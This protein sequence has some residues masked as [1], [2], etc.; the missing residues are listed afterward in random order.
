MSDQHDTP[1]SVHRRTVLGGLAGLGALGVATGLSGSTATASPDALEASG[2]DTFHPGHPR[3][4]HVGEKLWNS[5]FVGPELIGGRDNL[6]P[7][8]PAAEADTENYAPEDFEWSISSKPDDSEAEL[9]YQSSLDP[10]QPR[11]DEGRDN[12]TEFEADVPGTY[13]LEL[14]G[15]DG[16]H[17]LTI[18]AF[19]EPDSAAGGPPRIE[20]EGEYDD[21]TFTIG[22]N[23]ALAP[24]SQA[25][26]DA[27]EVVFLADDRDALSTDDIETDADALTGQVDVDALEGEAARVH[28]VVT[29]GNHQSV[30][31][32]I[33]LEPDGEISL[34]NRA[35][36]WM[37]DGVMYQIFPRSWSGERGETT[38]E[39]LIDGVD[40]LDEL[41]VDAVW[42]TP[43]VPAESVDK[44][45][46]NNNLSGFQ[47]DELPGGGPH[48][49]DTND[50][51]GVAEDLAFDGMD[52]VE[53][54]TAFV[55]ACHERDIKVV[56]DL[57]INHAGRGHP[58]FQDTIAEQ[59]TEPPAPDWEYPPVEAWNEDSKYFDWW[60]R[61]EA[62]VTHDGEVVDPAPQTTGFWGLRVMPNWNFDNVA[63]REH[64]LAVAEFW[65]GEVGVDG[66]R[67]DIA[68]GAPHS[69][70]KD[71]REVVRDNDSEFL[72]LD[73]AIPKDRTFSE[74][75]FDMHFDTDGF[76][77][78]THDV[79]NGLASPSNL[80]DDVRARQEDGFPEYSLL[81]NA[82]ENHDEHRLLNQTVADI[83][84]PNHDEL[85][86]EDWEAGATLQ[87]ACWAAGVTLPGVP[88]VYYGQERQISRYGEGRH[89]GEDDPRGIAAD[90][91]VDIGADVRPGGRQR[92]FMNWDEY[93]E[94][95]FE[96][97]KDLID[98]YHEID[99]LKNDAALV[100]EWYDSDD[101][102]L[103]FGR[104]GSHLS[105]V[106][107]PERAVVIVN[108]ET[109]GLATVELRSEV[110]STDV[111]SG[112]DIAVSSDDERT[113]VDVDEVAILE[114]PTFYAPGD[115]I[116]NLTVAPGT[117][118][119]NGRYRYPTGEQFTDG[120]FDM[121]GVSVHDG[122]DTH[123][124]RVEVRGDLVNHEGYEG[125]FTDQHIQLYLSDG[126]GDGTEL[127]RGG[128]NATFAEPYQY[129]VIADG[130]HGVRVETADGAHV[131]TG[132]VSANPADDSILL[133]FPKGALSGG[134][135]AMNLSILMLG[136]DPE[137]P[138]NVRQVTEDATETT[139]GGAQND[140]A[141]NV[142]DLTTPGDVP[143]FQALAY[144][145][146]TLATI[147]Y[148]P[149]ATDLEEIATFDEPTGE[150]YGPGTYEYP[151]SD[152]FYEGAWDIDELTVSASRDNVEFSFTMATE[153]QNPWG[154]P[155]PFS[156][157]F[158]QIY[159]YD[160]ATDGPE[161]VSGRAGLNANMAS[162]YNYRIVVNGES[163][164]TVESADGETVTSNVET[165]VEGRT[166]SIRVPAD[167]IGWDGDANGGIGIA[168]LVAPFDGFGEGNVRGIGTEAEEY[169]IG[170][171]TGTNDPAVMD[172]ITP[173]GVDR[174]DV[175]SEYGED[176]LVEIP[177]V[178][179]GEVDLPDAGD[180]DV[181]D[182][183]E[184]DADEED[185]DEEAD[186]DEETDPDD[187]AD[188]AG[189][190]TV[191]EPDE[192]ADDDGM[193]GFG[194]VVGA[195]GL[196]GGGA[197]AA[198]RFASERDEGD[199]K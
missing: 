26:R 41:G 6:A 14:E 100:G 55:D 173:D 134:I 189:D 75:E 7:S 27:L 38:F 81:L 46:G 198:K 76:T 128:V 131:E 96:F 105:E 2:I 133:E 193:P 22:T 125:G 59:G 119:G 109:D 28:A 167:A 162:P 56:F 9:T 20:L 171:G 67:C 141:P 86:D 74:N 39:D 87:R 135:E 71:I 177:F 196:A 99:V 170:G 159:I 52:P 23:A 199:E 191:T 30:L 188:D 152:D 15:P 103:V 92:A 89:L 108:F 63:V 60:D 12:V 178:V 8:V 91:S 54:Y 50:Y 155:R 116:A 115:R 183:D 58:F 176:S 149:L 85:T 192:D 112:D 142:I 158:Y 88:F 11:Y 31:D 117:D 18:Y 180:V 35:P 17:E 132:T 190:D 77:T 98:T 90:G 122:A 169:T 25:S 194:A 16:T 137:A 174:I 160:P 43:V 68:W 156:H 111:I 163:N 33:E 66:F 40:Y 102:V 179:L 187:G 145:D 83:Y 36:E 106:S 151:T 148:V 48:G 150:P 113:T 84:N 13:V 34:P 1:T 139:F 124:V 175:L 118:D 186:T 10:D 107:G 53:A 42:M 126:S 21:G 153:V 101:R 79:A 154:L 24:N 130:E 62:P 61:L 80:Y 69:I 184:E 168:A 51:F 144:S 82:V 140:S 104:D 138:G 32:T 94:D 161:S 172:M 19:P 127:A 129:R 70:W 5:A 64:F 45:F 4:V 49:Y 166:V 3:F 123:Q 47:E 182:E 143:N 57:V 185:H 147:P 146:G 95:H 136:Y 110:L 65:S 164:E 93:D 165:N 121:V 29:D 78:T 97:Y 157:Q 44:L 195:A 197:L 120:I 72:M 114:T 37:E 73:E 181:S